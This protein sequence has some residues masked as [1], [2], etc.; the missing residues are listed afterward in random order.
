[1][2]NVLITGG[3]GF[4]GSHL[5]K[6]LVEN[7]YKVRILDNLSPQIHGDNAQPP[8]W[9]NDLSIEL[10]L[11]DITSRQDVSSAIKEIDC[12]VHLAAE[13]GTGQSM[14]QI[15]RYNQV[16]VQG[17][18]ILLDIL[19]TQTHQ[20]KKILLASSRSIYGEG[21]YVCQNCNIDSINPEPRSAYQLRQH[22]WEPICNCCK[23]TLHAVPTK[24]SDNITPASIYASTKFMQ[25]ELIR[26]FAQS[27]GIDYCFLR[28]QN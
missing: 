19:T 18:A 17:T 16:N 6:L 25:E 8:S 12:I 10:I 22:I 2:K 7:N 27:V 21:T 15:E 20:V 9:I 14:Y 13:T 23:H 24:E 4:I 11:G 5:S 26:I 3:A 28:L 1:M